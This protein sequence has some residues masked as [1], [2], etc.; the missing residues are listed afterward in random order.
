MPARAHKELMARMGSA[1]A[2]IAIVRDRGAGRVRP[3]DGGEAL[4]TDALDDPVDQANLRRGLAELAR[5]HHA[6]GARE[7]HATGGVVAPWRRGEELN[8][9]VARL[10]AAPLGAGGLPVLSAHQ[11]GSA[12]MGVDPTTSVAGPWGELHDVAAVWIGDTSAFPT[13]LGVN[14][15]VTCMALAHRTAEAMADALDSGRRKR[16]QDAVQQQDLTPSR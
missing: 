5:L 11:M 13:A 4:V 2:F 8:E 1:A 16:V 7:I 12:R 15:M 14:P 3:D 6:A 9:F 10:A